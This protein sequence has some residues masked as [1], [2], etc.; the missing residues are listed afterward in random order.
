MTFRKVLKGF[1]IFCAC[2]CAFAVLGIV[3]A[4]DGGAALDV[5][6]G[7]FGLLALSGIFAGLSY[8]I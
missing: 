7:A 8:L 6:P 4:I 5:V 3:G 2:C 1:A